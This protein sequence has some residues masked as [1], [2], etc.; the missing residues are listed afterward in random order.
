MYTMRKSSD[1]DFWGEHFENY[2]MKN[3]HEK[4]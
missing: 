4:S 3:V 2:M 1:H